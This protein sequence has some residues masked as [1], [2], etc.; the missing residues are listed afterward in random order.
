LVLLDVEEVDD[1]VMPEGVVIVL[2]LLIVPVPLV[3]VEDFDMPAGLVIVL[4]LVVTFV[5]GWVV[6]VV[7]VFDELL[8]I[9]PV[10]GCVAAGV[11]A[12][13]TEAPSM[14]RERRKPKMHFIKDGS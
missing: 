7:I 10:A 11:W 5:P 4:D 6:L 12:W 13:A 9:V 14:L 8:L 2:D 3:M 1:F